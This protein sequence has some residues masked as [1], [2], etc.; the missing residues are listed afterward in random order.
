MFS[1][2]QNEENSTIGIEHNDTQTSETI[3]QETRP[4]RLEQLSNLKAIS[5]MDMYHM[6]AGKDSR[7]P[8]F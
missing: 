2:Y 6:S 3:V 7:V 1:K 8:W 5:K 4:C